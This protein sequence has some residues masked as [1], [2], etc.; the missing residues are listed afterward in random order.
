MKQRTL[1]WGMMEL[2]YNNKKVLF[3]CDEPVAFVDDKGFHLVQTKTDNKC[4][5]TIKSY[6]KLWIQLFPEEERKK[7]YFTLTQINDLL[8][9]RGSYA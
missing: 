9:S 6:I 1:G 8:E 5:N 3:S 4:K 2:T 7:Y